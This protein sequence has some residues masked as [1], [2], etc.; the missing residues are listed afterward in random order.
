MAKSKSSGDS[1]S[2]TSSKSKAATKK[3]A[4]PVNE[5]A[6][7]SVNEEAYTGPD[8]RQSVVDRRTVYTGLERRRGAGVRRPDFNKQAEEG[9]MDS[10]QFLFVK[11]IDAFKRV[12]DRP[13]PSWSE[14]LEVMRKLG[15]RK[16]VESE[17]NIAGA[18]DWTEAPD[19]PAFKEP[20]W[21]PTAAKNEAA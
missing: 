7:E 19:A 5:A 1:K 13:Y 15:Y 16:T 6:N 3:A 8:R 18:E 14:V 10:E 17:L 4:E 12:N 20:E 9:E 21:E 2:K 11:A